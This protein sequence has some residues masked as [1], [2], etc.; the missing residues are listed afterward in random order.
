MV[1]PLLTQLARTPLANTTVMSLGTPDL[2]EAARTAGVAA[3]AMERVMEIAAWP[4]R[5]NPRTQRLADDFKKRS[6]G[7]PLDAE[8]GYAHEAVLI[9]AD[10]VERAASTDSA[11]RARRV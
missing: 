1:G 3:P 11:P 4:N 7:R 10:A 8:S 9:V 5:R 6:G 2:V